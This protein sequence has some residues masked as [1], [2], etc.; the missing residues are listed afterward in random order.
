MDEE[1]QRLIQDTIR[2]NMESSRTTLL[3]E[4]GSMFNKI[5]AENNNMQLCKISSLVAAE[6]P[7]FKRKSNEEQFKANSKVL[8]KLNEA[9]NIL[10]QENA[11]GAKANITEGVNILFLHFHVK[12]K[13]N[14]FFF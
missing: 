11:T 12:K 5:S 14:I 10:E 6:H 13:K 2:Q 7:T 4:I 3:E 8:L 1:T 9:N